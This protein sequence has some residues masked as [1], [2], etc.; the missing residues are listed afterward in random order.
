MLLRSQ[1][2]ANQTRQYHVS[3]RFPKKLVPHI[4][5]ERSC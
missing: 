1:R 2:T 5:E 3:I 4:G